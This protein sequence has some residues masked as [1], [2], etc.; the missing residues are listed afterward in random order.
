MCYLIRS[1]N[2]TKN[3]APK[4]FFFFINLESSG[5]VNLITLIHTFYLTPLF[6]DYLSINKR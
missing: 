3:W 5:R 6:I 2:R 4:T 1:E